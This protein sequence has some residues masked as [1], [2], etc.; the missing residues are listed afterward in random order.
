MK[1][2]VVA[3]SGFAGINSGTIKNCYADMKT[4]SKINTSAFCYENEG[5][6]LTSWASYDSKN[7]KLSNFCDSDKGNIE[8]CF[9][10][11]DKSE[12]TPK[13]GAEVSGIGEDGKFSVL[14]LASDQLREKFLEESGI[15][16][17][18]IWTISSGKV[19][20]KK[21][22]L[23]IANQ[24]KEL[25]TPI[26][27]SEELFKF[28]QGVNNGEEEFTKGKFIL[29]KNIDLKGAK[30]NPIG[31]NNR[32][33][34]EGIFDGDGYKIKNFVL[35]GKNLEYAGFFGYIKGATIANLSIDGI[36][37]KG[38]YKG[39]FVA[40]NKSG[41]IKACSVATN[42]I[43]GDYSAGFVWENTG[44]IECCSVV[45]KAKKPIVLLI[46]IA[47]LSLLGL[48]LLGALV[49]F[50]LNQAQKTNLDYYPPVGVASDIEK[51]DDLTP[52]TSGNVTTIEYSG[53]IEAETGV[54]TASLDYRNPGSSNHH[55]VI[56]VQ[57]TDQTLLDK[58]GKTGRTAEDQAKLDEANYDPTL[59][60]VTIGKTGAIPPGYAVSTVELN[61]LPD[62]TVLPAGEYDAILYMDLYNIYTNE[63]AAM[64]TQAPIKLLIKG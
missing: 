2:K 41:T 62:G 13:E 54:G 20:F 64:Q 3:N 53:Y 23:K 32:V 31:M 60:R 5:D 11:V 19:L 12:S 36:F 58:I 37:K 25:F 29:T 43:L 33:A 48:A 8:S 55:V 14:S 59:T 15:D 47:S 27:S 7:K 61:A 49:W 26:S 1:H 44:V 45:G 28:V 42:L 10:M 21:K 39:S 46:P 56:N 50:A 63:K 30:W 22:G 9:C 6:I 38:R 52:S 18:K 51:M 17:Q 57:L 35:D 34:F 16:M 4:K 24:K 40:V